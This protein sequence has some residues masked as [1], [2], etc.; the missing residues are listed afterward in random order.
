[1]SFNNTANE[2][3]DE[4][5]TKQVINNVWTVSGTCTCNTYWVG[6][7]CWTA[8]CLNNCTGHGQCNDTL[9]VPFCNNCDQG[10]MGADCSTPC[11]GVQQPMNSGQYIYS[12]T[13]I[14]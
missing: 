8:E 12:I 2:C 5:Q 7:G 4:N 11:Y 10:W 3:S 1:M 14:Y 13:Y 6:E 9:N